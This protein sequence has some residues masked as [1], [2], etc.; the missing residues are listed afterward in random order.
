MTTVNPW[1]STG[2]ELERQRVQAMGPELGRRYH[3]LWNDFVWLNL[4]LDEFKTLY[5]QS[6]ERVELLN[7]TAPH[8]FWQIQDMMWREM[9]LSL[10][11]LVDKPHSSGIAHLTIRGLPDLIHH[12][13]NFSHDV[14][15]LVVN[16]IQQCKFASDLR[17]RLLVHNELDLKLKQ[18]ARPLPSAGLS[19][20]EEAIRAI[21]DLLARIHT[22]YFESE[23]IFSPI[24]VPGGADALVAWL[25]LAAQARQ[26]RQEEW[27][28]RLR[29]TEDLEA[30]SD[31][32]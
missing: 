5:M 14:K 22:Q 13:A 12:D 28:R 18:A 9:L 19:D 6:A 31:N 1:A 24:G 25:D 27:R 29:G 21:K 11:R 20:V 17:D 32:C 16:V 10:A 4:T 15:K 23:L 8:F 2:K 26:Q 7:Q 3:A 30:P